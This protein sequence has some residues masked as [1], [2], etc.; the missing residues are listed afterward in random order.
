MASFQLCPVGSPSE[1]PQ[2]Q[3]AGAVQVAALKVCVCGGSVVGAVVGSVVGAVVG[4]V[5]DSVVGIVAG[6]VVGTVVDSVVGIVVDSVVV[7]T[8]ESVVDAVVVS[9]GMSVSAGAS[10]AGKVANIKT[11]STTM[12]MILILPFMYF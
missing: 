5:V 10:E 12:A 9:P 6:A 4:T 8:V 11:A 7:E 1:A 2:E 3:V